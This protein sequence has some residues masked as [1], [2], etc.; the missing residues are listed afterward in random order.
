MF[1]FVLVSFIA[2]LM[3]LY[4]RKCYFSF[5]YLLFVGMYDLGT[6]AIYKYFGDEYYD[7]IIKLLPGISE[8]LFSQFAAVMFFYI[9]FIG[10]GLIIGHSFNSRRLRLSRVS[11]L[12][13]ERDISI[14]AAVILFLFGCISLAQGGGHERIEQYSQGSEN[15]VVTPFHFY[16]VILA[17]LVWFF[18]IKTFTEKNYYRSSL[19]AFL[20]IPNI[21][22]LFQAGRRQMF[23]PL[24]FIGL[25][26][27]LRYD[28]IKKSTK[29]FIALA[30]TSFFVVLF[31]FQF[32]LRYEEMNKL[33]GAEFS[34]G[35]FWE[36]LFPL[37]GEFI[38]SGST[39]LAAYS[40]YIYSNHST[41]LGLEMFI[42]SLVSSAVPLVGSFMSDL[43][44]SGSAL[45][46]N[47]LSNIA[48]FGALTTAAQGIAYFGLF[49]LLIFGLITGL[50]LAFADK[51]V[52][53]FFSTRYCFSYFNI[54]VI[55]LLAVIF[56]KYR[57][58]LID[59]IGT[60]IK[61]LSMA[62]FVYLCAII[63]RAALNFLFSGRATI[64]MRRLNP[65]KC[66]SQG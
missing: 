45:A 22:D 29:V 44:S 21:I 15:V 57:S 5:A 33:N 24:L 19:I 4:R 31:A 49:G 58:G 32:S 66:R 56:F 64:R 37:I 26:F 25:L 27:L 53:Q 59:S 40:E 18:L 63:F 14:T 8:R 54:V 38:G 36:L 50:A 55:S 12:V 3:F 42:S 51:F 20:A 48:P 61:M 47:A 9:L 17:P 16:G 7:L 46:D 52:I 28:S 30:L 39:T 43:L 10:I 34:Y 60:S 62:A 2:L 6:A 35:S 11:F 41:P 23:V 13:S 65:R 1:E